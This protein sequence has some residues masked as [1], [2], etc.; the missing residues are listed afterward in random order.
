MHKNAHAL[1]IHPG[2]GPVLAMLKT[3]HGGRVKGKLELQSLVPLLRLSSNA[4]I[5]F[6]IGLVYKNM[7]IA[8]YTQYT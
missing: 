3:A 6:N 7:V 5:V 8:P 1:F 4:H 2:R